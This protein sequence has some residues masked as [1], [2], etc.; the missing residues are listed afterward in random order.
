MSLRCLFLVQGEGR[1]HMTQ[2]LAMQRLLTE[3]GHEVV[4]AVVGTS[5]RRAVPGFFLE[6]LQAPITFAPSPNFV[7][8]AN[9]RGVRPVK[10]VLR[11]LGRVPSF[12]RGLSVIDAA[13]EQHEP[14]VVVNFFEPLGGAYTAWYQPA[15]PF[16][17]VAHQYMFH[18]PAYAFPAGQRLDRWGARTFAHITAWGASARL[19]LSLYPAEDRPA[20]RLFVLP[21]LLRDEVLSRPIGPT[22]PFFLVYILNSGYAEE[23]IRWHE[24]NPAVP[25]HCFWDRPGAADVEHHD[26]TLTFHQLDDVRFVDM[27]ARC[28]G[29]VCTAGFESVGEAMY[30]GKPVQVVPV[31]N[32]YEQQCNAHDTVRAGAGI[33][34]TSFNIDRLRRYREDY[35][36]DVEGFRAWMQSERDRYVR[37]IERAVQ[38]S[39][40]VHLASASSAVTT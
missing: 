21:P 20:D 33:R 22:E 39:A 26:A 3:A 31:D 38:R 11:E 32:H 2:A 14:D 35:A 28:R 13:I 19:A 23:I 27:M 18:H 12:L 4:G 9:R 37:E 5:D 1:G 8:D 16:V 34:S 40:T 29:L 15:V 25:L 6:K 30:L 36:H 17:C 10:T 24:D 7:A